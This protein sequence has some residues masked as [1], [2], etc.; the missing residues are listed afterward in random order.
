MY[1][2]NNGLFWLKFF[3]KPAKSAP[4][5]KMMLSFPGSDRICIILHKP[6]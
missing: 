5:A 6:A 4:W 2:R 1:T 3:G